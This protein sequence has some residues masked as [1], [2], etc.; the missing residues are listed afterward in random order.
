MIP[1]KNNQS[2]PLHFAQFVGQSAA[3]HAQIVSKLL[4]VEG[5]LKFLLPAADGLVA[6][7]GQEPSPDRFGGGV[8]DAAGKVQIFPG[9]DSQKVPYE[10]T[11]MGA[12]FRTGFQNPPYI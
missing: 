8:E 6:E 12:G 10:L 5:D 7:I 4:S 2:F 11:V 9:G 3:V 1:G